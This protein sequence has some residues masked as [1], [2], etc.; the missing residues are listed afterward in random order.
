MPRIHV[1]SATLEVTEAGSGP[2]LLLVHGFPLDH[3]M[4]RR[5][6][7]T[8]AMTH[9]VVAPDLR[10]FGLSTVTPGIVTMD[11]YADDL[12]LLLDAMEIREPITFCG[13]SMGGYIAWQFVERHRA[14]LAKLILCDTKAAPDTPEAAK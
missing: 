7:D 1:D 13:L 4:W 9:R 12:A 3:Q 2:V 5:Q 6:I 10:G 14:R 11:R 8:F